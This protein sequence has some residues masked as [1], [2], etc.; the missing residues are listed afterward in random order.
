MVQQRPGPPPLAAESSESENRLTKM[1]VFVPFQLVADSK[2]NKSDKENRSRIFSRI[3]C[4]TNAVDQL[5][6]T[7]R[8]N[9]LFQRPTDTYVREREYGE[10]LGIE[11]S[12]EHRSL[13]CLRSLEDYPSSHVRHCCGVCFQTVEHC[14][15]LD[16]ADHG[17]IE[18]HVMPAA[19][20]RGRNSKVLQ[21]KGH[22]GVLDRSLLT[23]CTK[24]AAARR[25]RMSQSRPRRCCARRQRTRVFFAP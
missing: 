4:A 18:T 13:W 16:E 11:P 2:K 23:D 10:T 25:D 12:H 24:A 6:E 1:V 22:G 9:P 8:P 14:K 3:R 20:T 21:A 5:L 15:T 7:C 19:S 17:M